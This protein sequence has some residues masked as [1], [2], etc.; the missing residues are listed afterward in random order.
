MRRQLTDPHRRQR[1]PPTQRR[2]SMC[3]LVGACWC[4]PGSK[5]PGSKQPG[6]RRPGSRRPGPQQPR[7]GPPRLRPPG[8]WQPKPRRRQRRSES[9]PNANGSAQAGRR[10]RP[11]PRVRE[12]AARGCCPCQRDRRQAHRTRPHHVTGV[13]PAADGARPAPSP[14]PPQAMGLSVRPVRSA[15][16]HCPTGTHCPSLRPAFGRRRPGKDRNRT[17]R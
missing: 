8:L 16:P 15:A 6:S 9:R 13:G 3:A 2:P 4:G 1:E 10:Q 11:R 17:R 5:Q 14:I 7:S 12:S